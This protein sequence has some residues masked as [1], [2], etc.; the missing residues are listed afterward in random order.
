MGH[1]LKI[2]RG[3]P[4]LF[5]HHETDKAYAE[6]SVEVE[7]GLAGKKY[8]LDNLETAVMERLLAP[9]H[10]S[11]HAPTHDVGYQVGK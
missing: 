1:L 5:E 11:F 9:M 3:N 8:Q 7:L 6:A 4:L 2:W 10:L